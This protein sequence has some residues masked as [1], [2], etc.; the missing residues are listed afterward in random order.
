MSA[1]FDTTG[2]NNVS[3]GTT[4]AV[5]LTVG[6]GANR[7][8][9]VG[10]G[11]GVHTATGI[12]VTG[13]GASGWALVSGTDTGSAV[14]RRTLIWAATNPSTGSQ[15][16]T[17]TWTV[18]ADCVMGVVTAAGVDQTTPVVNGTSQT[19]ASASADTL[20][21]TSKTGDLTMDVAAVLATLSAP[22]QTQR[23]NDSTPA[24]V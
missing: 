19:A 5:T 13:A 22:T 18:N 1:T 10:L 23:W 11:F 15:T 8:V 12:A 21:I 14:T 7:A 20:V 2:T 3:L 17:A 24:T 9:M 16:V 4:V 6:T